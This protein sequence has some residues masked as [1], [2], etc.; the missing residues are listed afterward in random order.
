MQSVEQFVDDMENML[1]EKTQ[2][3][4]VKHIR[5]NSASVPYSVFQMP[6]NQKISVNLKWVNVKQKRKHWTRE[7]IE[8]LESAYSKLEASGKV[9]W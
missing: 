7:E 1:I 8:L 6:Q 5:C 4:K 9:A 3:V 2:G